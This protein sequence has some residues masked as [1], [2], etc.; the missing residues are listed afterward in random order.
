M[1]IHITYTDTD[2]RYT[3]TQTHRYTRPNDTQTYDTPDT[4]IQIPLLRYAA[5]PLPKRG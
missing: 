3:D 2:I 5:F 4:N 1:Y